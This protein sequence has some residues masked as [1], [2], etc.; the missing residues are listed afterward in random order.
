MKTKIYFICLAL[1]GLAS[2]LCSGC[3]DESILDSRP[4][5]F[6]NLYVYDKD[7]TSMID[8]RKEHDLSEEV[9]ILYQGKEY[10]VNTPELPIG[11][12]PKDP[13]KMYRDGGHLMFGWWDPY[14][15]LNLGFIVNWPDETHDTVHFVRLCDGDNVIHLSSLN[16]SAVNED[17]GYCFT[18]RHTLK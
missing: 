7:G 14:I 16:G 13:L 8:I 1:L 2:L 11:I 15:N 12:A 4:P 5:V 3:S 6:V 17:T 10:S 18:L 9:S